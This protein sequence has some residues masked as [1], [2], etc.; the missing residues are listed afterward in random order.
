MYIYISVKI[1]YNQFIY[2]LHTVHVNLKSINNLSLVK[3]VNR[4]YLIKM[5][6]NALIKAGRPDTSCACACYVGR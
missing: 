6:T 3:T 4:L 2:L 1:I 5:T